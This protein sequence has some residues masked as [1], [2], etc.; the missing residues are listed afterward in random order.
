VSADPAV[1]ER[2]A[3]TAQLN[4]PGNAAEFAQSIDEQVKQLAESAK[5]LG[6]K[7]KAQ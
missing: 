2:L 6:L 5:L 7:P 3:A 4:V 1:A